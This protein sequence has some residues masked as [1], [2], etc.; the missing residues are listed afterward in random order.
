MENMESIREY[1]LNS[2]N[3][4]GI[5]VP[6]EYREVFENHITVLADRISNNECV[7]IDVTEMENELK[8][9]NLQLAQE[10]LE[11]VFTKF[12]IEDRKAET[13]LLALYI[14]I[15]KEGGIN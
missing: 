3:E 10:V 15:A 12:N 9:E 7:N 11:P 6:E 4:R 1:I 2:L 8:E 14:N 5:C 13:A